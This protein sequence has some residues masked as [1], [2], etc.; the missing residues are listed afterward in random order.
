MYLDLHRCFLVHSLNTLTSAVVVISNS[1]RASDG[2]Q[3]T[4]PTN[5]QTLLM[6]Y[7]AVSAERGVSIRLQ[8]STQHNIIIM[9]QMLISTDGYCVNRNLYD[10]RALLFG[11][12]K[13]SSD[14]HRSSCQR[15]ATVAGFSKFYQSFQENRG[16]S[17]NKISPVSLLAMES[18]LWA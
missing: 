4:N 5:R 2:C 14:S 3:N 12:K 16:Y 15:L 9:L 6:F 17:L 13:S 7:T 10:L 1:G 18:V 11:E 8:E